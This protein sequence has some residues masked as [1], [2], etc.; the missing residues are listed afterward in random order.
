MIER[1]Y[2]VQHN[3]LTPGAPPRTWTERT[4]TAEE[5]LAALGLPAGAELISVCPAKYMTQVSVTYELPE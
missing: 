5:F 2:P 1:I 3:R 4:Y